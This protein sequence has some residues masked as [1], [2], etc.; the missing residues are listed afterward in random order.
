MNE[1]RKTEPSALSV[2]LREQANALGFDLIG[3]APAVPPPGYARYLD[4]LAQGHAGPLVYLETRADHRRDPARLLDGVRSVVMAGLV[5]AQPND[6]SRP[7]P[8]HGKVARYARG[9]DYHQLFWDR[10][11]R[12]GAWLSER[13][14]GSRYRSV[15]DSAPLLERDFARLAGFG[16]IGKNTM[17]IHKKRGSYFLLGALLT[18]VDL[19]PD[20]PF[21]SNH[22]G[23]C[24]A[25]LDACPTGAL[26]APYTLDARRCI[27]TW[28]IETKGPLPEEAE[29]QLHGWV[30]G[31]DICQEVCPWNRKAPVGSDPALLPRPEW[32]NPDLLS[33]FEMEEDAFRK[34][35]RGTALKRAKRSGLLR[36]AAE[37]LA[38]GEVVEAY[39][40]LARVANDTREDPVVRDACRKA[41]ERLARHIG[42]SASPPAQSLP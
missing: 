17:L 22:C 19:E 30:F 4:W 41:V 35:L 33:W 38:S 37:V 39:D 3:I 34:M 28:T 13:V 23:T 5:Y 27:S 40:V 31:C 2:E 29:G 36:N 26:P 7:S 11:D 25:C 24:T 12:L 1:P 16:W 42:L 18:D 32:F 9:A 6:P 14:P 21:H 8:R 10:L 20:S 15:S